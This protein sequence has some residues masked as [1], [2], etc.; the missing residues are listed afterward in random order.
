MGLT[1]KFVIK[2]VIVLDKGTFASNRFEIIN[3]EKAGQTE[4][5]VIRFIVGDVYTSPDRTELGSFLD[6]NGY[7]ADEL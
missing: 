2:E 3:D 1:T 6:K 4:H 7:L 5:K